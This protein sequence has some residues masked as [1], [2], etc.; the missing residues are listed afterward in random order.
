MVRIPRAV[1]YIDLN[2]LD[3]NY[4]AIRSLLPEEV[5]ILAVV[6]SDAYGHGAVE[7]ARRLESNGAYFLGVATIDEGVELR[8]SGITAPILIMSGVFPWDDVEPLFS[9]RL[10]PVVYDY[11]TLDRIEE[12][13]DRWEDA[14]KVH[15]KVDTGMGRVGF[16]PDEVSHVAERVKDM[17]NVEIEGLMSHFSA[18]ETRNDYGLNQIKVFRGV[19]RAV[20]DAGVDPE[21]IHMANSGALTT[22]PEAH[23]NMV[24]VGINLYGSHAAGFLKEKISL[25]QVMRLVSKVAHIREFPSGSALSYGGTFTTKLNTKVAYI[26]LGYGDGY[27][28]ML[29]NKGSVLIKDQRCSII[30]RICM[31]WLLA[32]VTHLAGLDVGEEVILLGC[33]ETRTISADE[34]AEYEGTIPYEILCR[35]SKRIMR[36]YV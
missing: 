3:G 5:R 31:D 36:V 19:V 15:V 35:I 33:G 12:E 18:S 16:M 6:K 24:R 22:Y 25:R 21:I 1:A 7:V 8:D 34:I 10:T 23:F 4:G 29:S 32:D 2:A 14:L 9:S 27:P 28:R 13:G 26:P 11:A 17:K 30:G 20:K